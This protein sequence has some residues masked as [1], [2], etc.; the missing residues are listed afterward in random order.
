MDEI[1]NGNDGNSNTGT[2]NGKEMI[3][4]C[5]SLAGSV[6]LKIIVYR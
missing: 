5:T 6:T 1:N 4:E 2:R 3:A